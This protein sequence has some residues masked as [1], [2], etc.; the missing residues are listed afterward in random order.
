MT[1]IG[2]G[3]AQSLKDADVVVGD[4]GELVKVFNVLL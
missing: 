1:A 2:V 4:T 3:C